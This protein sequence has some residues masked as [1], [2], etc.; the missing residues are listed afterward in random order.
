MPDSDRPTYSLLPRQGQARCR[1]AAGAPGPCALHDAASSAR[2]VALVPRVP[3]GV[4]EPSVPRHVLSNV[5]SGFGR[6]AGHARL[7]LHA[8]T[9]WTC[10]FVAEQSRA[11]F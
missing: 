1:S 4:I 10:T 11:M 7:H 9:A 2:A 3:E 8:L 5:R 6:R